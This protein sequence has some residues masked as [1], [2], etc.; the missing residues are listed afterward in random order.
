LLGP[1]GTIAV[2]ALLLVLVLG[3]MALRVIRRP[4][5]TVWRPATV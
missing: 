3:W 4:E 1:N 2:G 5:N